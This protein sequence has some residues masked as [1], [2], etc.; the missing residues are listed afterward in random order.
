MRRWLWLIGMLM[1]TGGL[2]AQDRVKV[3]PD[4]TRI[5]TRQV[6]LLDG[7]PAA[8]IALEAKGQVATIVISRGLVNRLAAR[9][10]K[11]IEGRISRMDFLASGRAR[12]LLKRLSVGR[13]AM[14]CQRVRGQLPLDTTFLIGWLLEKGRAA[15]YTH[16]LTLPEPVVIV[17][18]TD[19]QLF[20]FEEFVLLDGKVIW[21]YGTWVS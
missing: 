14:G 9:D 8:C 13:D 10:E 11:A 1:L 2:Q 12:D 15:V 3:T 5:T 21:G 19:T 17:R 7:V 18:H 4:G 20:G 16:R 6:S